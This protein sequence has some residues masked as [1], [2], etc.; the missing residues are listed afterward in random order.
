MSWDGAWMSASNATVWGRV[1]V[2]ST[3]E[4]LRCRMFCLQTTDWSMAWWNHHGFSAIKIKSY[5]Y[6]NSRGKPARLWKSF[7]LLSQ[8]AVPA[9]QYKEYVVDHRQDGS[10]TYPELVQVTQQ[11]AERDHEERQQ[12]ECIVTTKLKKNNIDSALPVKSW[13]RLSKNCA[14]QRL[15]QILWYSQL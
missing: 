13:S 6:S 10:T 15:R 3:L 11:P 12:P 7:P 2:Y 5:A 9:F 8:R 4:E 1:A 14:H